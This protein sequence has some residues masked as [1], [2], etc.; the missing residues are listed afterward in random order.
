MLDA[1][2]RLT[3]AGR[4][5]LLACDPGA[6]T[7]AYSVP[8][9]NFFCGRW[10]RGAGWWPDRLLRL[11]RTGAATIASSNDP[12]AVAAAVHERWEVDGAV[13]QLTEPI[14]HHSYPSVAAY[15]SKF[16]R[17]TA[18]EAAGMR[19]RASLMSL[20]VAC[21]SVPLRIAWLLFVRGGVFD[22]WRG[23]YVS[24]GSAC[25][26]AVARWKAWRG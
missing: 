22:G 25:Y 9:K 12:R 5:E 3:Q 4:A 6:Q 24:V 16:A 20:A 23:A 1:D 19:S 15:R 8:R 14:E 2:E 26:P 18:L 21:M 10:I 13:A 17:Y 11:F 7:R